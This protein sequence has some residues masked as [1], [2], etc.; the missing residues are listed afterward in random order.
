[1]DVKQLSSKITANL[2]YKEELSYRV[3]YR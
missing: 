2:E 1:L 3:V